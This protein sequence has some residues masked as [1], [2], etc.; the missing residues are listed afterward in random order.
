[1]GVL[2]LWITT[3]LVS[4]TANPSARHKIKS[5]TAVEYKYKIFKGR[6]QKQRERKCVRERE[7]ER[8]REEGRH[9]YG[10]WQININNLYLTPAHFRQSTESCSRGAAL[11][12]II[13][14]NRI[15]HQYTFPTRL[16]NSYVRGNWI[17]AGSRRR[18]KA[19]GKKIQS[20]GG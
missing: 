12:K 9:T 15:Y 5:S 1:M 20:G 17:K 2:Y 13:W 7:R 19:R 4:G 18:K 14:L 8:E 11:I 3:S 6:G 16:R 10:P